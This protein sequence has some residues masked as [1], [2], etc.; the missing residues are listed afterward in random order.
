VIFS[1]ESDHPFDARYNL[2]GGGPASDGRAGGVRCPDRRE[3]FDA[4]AQAKEV[5]LHR[6]ARRTLDVLSPSERA[7]VERALSLLADPSANDFVKANVYRLRTPDP[8][9]LMRATPEIRILFD[10]TSDGIQV[11]DVVYRDRLKSFREMARSSEDPV[12]P[13]R[14]RQAVVQ[15]QVRRRVK[16]RRRVG[17]GR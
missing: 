12:S 11:L 14:P 15:P 7:S 1:G 3:E 17:E 16:R 2:P 5:T 8:T 13:K 10:T 4:M 6:R 9:Y